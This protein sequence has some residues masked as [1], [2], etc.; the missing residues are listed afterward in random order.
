MNI[1]V[2][3]ASLL[4]II[5]TIVVVI[6]SQLA[7]QLRALSIPSVSI[8]YAQGSVFTGRAFIS[9][10]TDWQPVWVDL[11]WQWCPALN[12]LRWCVE[13]KSDKGEANSIV[14]SNG[15]SLFIN[16]LFLSAESVDMVF[17]GF[18]SAT[19]DIEA[20]IRSAKIQNARDLD[21]LASVDGIVMLSNI[22]AMGFKFK[23]HRI[24]ANRA[25]NED[26]LVEVSGDQAN[27]TAS[28]DVNG[29]YSAELTLNPPENIASMIGRA[30]TKNPDGSFRYAVSGTLPVM[31]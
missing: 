31:H 27:G 10:E 30:L 7:S 1:K 17:A 20:S 16:D 4:L 21:I 12:P 28:A 18:V 26:F 11:N 6:V 19:A 15:S 24:N 5:S 23:N 25:E 8:E 22:D 13:L 29:Q 2:I 3:A 9:A 14:S